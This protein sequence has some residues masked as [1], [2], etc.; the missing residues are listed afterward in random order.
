MDK[1]DGDKYYDLAV[2]KI[3]EEEYQEAANLFQNALE[4]YE[5]VLGRD[6]VDTADA[7]HGLAFSCEKHQ[8]AEIYEE[9]GRLEEAAEYDEKASKVFS[10]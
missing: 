2:E 8:L 6:H 1:M 3:E 4:I 7:L 9:Q 10:S 5:E